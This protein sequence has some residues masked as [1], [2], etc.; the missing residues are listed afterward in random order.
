MLEA[1][2][3]QAVA[4]NNW[5]QALDAWSQLPKHLQDL[6]KA[7]VFGGEV[8]ND[9]KPSLFGVFRKFYPGQGSHADGFGGGSCSGDMSNRE[10]VGIATDRE[11]ASQIILCDAYNLSV[12]GNVYSAVVSELNNYDKGVDHVSFSLTASW[13]VEPIEPNQ[14]LPEFRPKLSQMTDDVGGS[15]IAYR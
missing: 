3:E 4:L 6:A 7:K 1:T 13:D 14:L 9:K 11:M 8:I 12:K 5:V 2:N 10:L 15:D